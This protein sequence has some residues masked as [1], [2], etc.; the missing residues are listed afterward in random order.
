MLLRWVLTRDEGAV[1]KMWDDYGTFEPRLGGKLVRTVAETWSSVAWAYATANFGNTPKGGIEARWKF[2]D[3]VQPRQEQIYTALRSG[4]IRSWVS[5]SETG[6]LISADPAEWRPR[7]FFSWNGHDLAIP[8]GDWGRRFEIAEYVGGEDQ[9][10][11]VPGTVWVNPLFSAEDAK[12]L[13]PAV[14]DAGQQRSDPVSVETAQAAQVV[15]L[16]VEFV[17]WMEAEKSRHGTY[18]PRD[19]PGTSARKPWT[20]WISDHSVT[21]K[22]AQ[23]WVARHGLRNS[24]GRPRKIR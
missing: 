23:S 17:E 10:L 16:E 8:P 5:R 6:G 24:P 7:Q 12:K 22:V 13:W 1:L 21:H 11:P 20:Q 14:P 18:P 2:Q 4:K 9:P 3:D 19:P 15:E